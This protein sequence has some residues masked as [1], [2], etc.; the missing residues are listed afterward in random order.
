MSMLDCP[1]C[2]N[3]ICTCGHDYQDWTVKALEDQIKML[4]KVIDD[5][6]KK[7]K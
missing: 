4:Q 3:I 6:K 1:E 2:W 5:K 7:K